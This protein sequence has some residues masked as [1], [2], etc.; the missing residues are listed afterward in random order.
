MKNFQTQFNVS[1]FV[2]TCEFNP[3]EKM[4][5]WALSEQ[6]SGAKTIGYQHTVVPHASA[7]MFVSR[8]EQD[9]VPRAHKILTVGQK[10]KEIILRYETCDPSKISAACGLRF[11]YFDYPQGQRTNRGHILLALEGLPQV[12]EMTDYVLKQIASNN[13]YKLKIRTHPVLPLD[14]FVHQLSMDPRNIPGVLISKAA[15]LKEDLEWADIVIYWGTTVAL[16]AVSIGKPVI[17]YDMGSI[18]RYDPLFEVTD[19]K[20]VVNNLMPLAQVI[21]GIYNLPDEIYYTKREA[22][23][24]YIQQYFHRVTPDSLGLFQSL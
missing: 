17:H 14:K 12:A 19:F 6:S 2:F 10:P 9:I 22:V 1:D 3:L 24:G 15:S 18:V 21:D 16:E 13:Q 7:N 8:F 20:W 23:Q 4:C 11:E 5:L